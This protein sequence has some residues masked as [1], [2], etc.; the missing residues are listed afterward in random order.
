[1]PEPCRTECG[2]QVTYE[3]RIFSDGIFFSIPIGIDG[4]LHNCINIQNAQQ[5]F[6]ANQNRMPEVP[7]PYYHPDM[8]AKLSPVEKANL[9]PNV[10]NYKDRKKYR[11]HIYEFDVEVL[12][13]LE[14]SL[15]FKED[16]EELRGTI[17]FYLN[18]IFTFHA[19]EPTSRDKRLFIITRIIGNEFWYLE[20]LGFLYQLDGFYADAKMCFETVRLHY[21]NL[22]EDE[23][24]PTGGEWG[25]G[26][27]AIIDLMEQRIK[28]NDVD[29]DGVK[30]VGGVWF[31]ENWSEEFK[32]Y[33]K[34]IRKN[35]PQGDGT[36]SNY[37]SKTS[38]D[39]D[40]TKEGIPDADV[41]T[42]IFEFER[43]VL[44]SVVRKRFPSE[45]EMNEK[46][47]NMKRYAGEKVI[48]TLYDKALQHQE[49]ENKDPRLQAEDP[50]NVGLLRFLDIGDLVSLRH[51]P[52]PISRY[53]NDIES[54][55]HKLMGHPNVYEQN[56]L[57][58]TNNLVMAEI[59]LCKIFFGKYYSGITR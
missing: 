22:P 52:F 2:R 5:D 46:L 6:E 13:H 36:K 11:D 30:N 29:Q 23:P 39:A 1:M 8:I 32:N 42:E 10:L 27:T 38:L 33:W 19:S 54:F 4:A 41:R 55:R 17:G 58:Q 24:P 51:W 48:G 12:N 56:T 59:A 31:D 21:D 16:R 45:K 26:N 9:I 34:E 57:K 15:G 3:K 50:M 53:L 43:D 28:Q 35:K 7:E 40:L 49:K 37:Q 44:R 25:M 47:K 20:L 18:K 14:D